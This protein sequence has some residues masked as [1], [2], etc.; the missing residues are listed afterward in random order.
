[1]KVEPDGRIFPESNNSQ[2]IIDC[3]LALTQKLRIEIQLN[4]EVISI[5]KQKRFYLQTKSG[6]YEADKILIA[7]GGY[8]KP[9]NYQWLASLGHQVVASNSFTLYV[10]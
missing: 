1:M 8:S 4:S 2:T 3:F 7:S 5:E 6:A 10:Q 9:E